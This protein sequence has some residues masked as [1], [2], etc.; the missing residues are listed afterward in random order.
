MPRLLAAAL[1]LVCIA[2]PALAQ[3][4]RPADCLLFIDGREYIR[5]PCTFSPIDTDGSFQIMSLN[6]RTF[7]QVLISRPGFGDGYWNGG[8]Y[9]NHAHDP[10]GPL[11]RDEACWS[12]DRASVC[13]W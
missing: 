9:G 10:L 2:L 13:A 1:A 11:R 7:A 6:G 5:G 4:G 8:E 3:S 12:N